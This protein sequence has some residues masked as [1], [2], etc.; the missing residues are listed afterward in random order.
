[1][2]RSLDNILR[3][4]DA[5]H[6]LC[7]VSLGFER[8]T[9]DRL[10]MHQAWHHPHRHLDSPMPVHTLR[11]VAAL[12]LPFHVVYLFLVEP[13]LLI[14]HGGCKALKATTKLTLMV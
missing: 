7:I 2:A 13:H 3:V 6:G 12:L 10:G 4:M 1:M 9:A 14:S 8:H 5:K 11:H